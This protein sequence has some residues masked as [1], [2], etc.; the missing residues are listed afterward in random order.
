MDNLLTAVVPIAAVGALYV[1]VPV[2]VDAYRRFRGPKVVTCPETHE[3]AEVHVD[4]AHAAST[5]AVGK[6]E[7]HVVRCSRW[8]QRH[9]CAQECADQLESPT[10]SVL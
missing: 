5:A 4:A 1:V 6:P 10:G 2:V 9:Y 8:P 3:P 7:L